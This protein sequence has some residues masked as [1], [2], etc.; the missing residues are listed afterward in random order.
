MVEPVVRKAYTDSAEGQI[1][2][3][4]TAPASDSSKLPILCLHMSA[5]SSAIFEQLMRTFTAQGHACYAP[6]M[7]G[8]GASFD[9]SQDPPDIRWYVDLYLNVF[10][11]SGHFPEL[12]RGCHV[13][14][15]HS[16]GVIGVE[17]A[18]SHPGIVKSLAVVG[19]VLMDAAQREKARG[20][21]A[22]N[23]PV[24]DGS[25]LTRTWEYLQSHGGITPSELDLLQQETLD[26]VR[27]WKGRLQIYGCVFGDH[28]GPSLY[29]QV[30]Y[31]GD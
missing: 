14:G 5:S 19:P 21:Q 26:H 8:F 23:K 12:S 20:F 15:H 24:A 22:F 31:E 3:R 17:F 29:S 13:L 25:H 7:P 30:K 27:A 18:V 6:D 10:F 4:Y 16:G 28:D 11:K 1:H 9:P 2:Y